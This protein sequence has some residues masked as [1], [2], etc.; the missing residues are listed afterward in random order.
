MPPKPYRNILVRFMAFLDGKTYTN[1]QEFGTE[2]L[3]QITPED[4]CRYLSHIAYGKECPTDEDRP[5]NA[6]SN[7][8]HYVKKAISCFMPRRN[9]QWD[10]V[11][12]SGNPT[13]S[14]QV[15]SL[16]KLVK[17]HEV[18]K[19]GAESKVVRPLEY[20][21]FLNILSLIRADE[22]IRTVEKCRLVSVLTLQWQLI[23]RIDDIM[24]LQLRN[25]L[26]N[27]SNPFTL[28]AQMSWSKNIM[29]ERDSP[30]QIILASMDEKI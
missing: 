27:P 1:D 29:E 12:G 30:Q 11:N 8:L 24:K 26:W 14:I 3:V 5:V 15:N 10:N 19:E 25:I 28:N 22:S 17:K 4:L 7:T 21:E 9:I 13:K 6:R 2:R 16:I 20:D 23:G 18:R